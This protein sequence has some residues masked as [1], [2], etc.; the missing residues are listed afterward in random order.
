MSASVMGLA[1]KEALYQVFFTFKIFTFIINI[2]L[3]S[4]RH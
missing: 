1:H 2:F 3:S 4:L